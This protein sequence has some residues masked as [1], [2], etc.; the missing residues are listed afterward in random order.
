MELV[1]F[2]PMKLLKYSIS[3]IVLLAVTIACENSHRN[4]YSTKRAELMLIYNDYVAHKPLPPF[5]KIDS[6]LLYFEKYG[7]DEER[8]LSRYCKGASYYQ[9]NCRRAAYMEMRKSY[10]DAPSHLSPMNREI[11][12]GVL[13]HLQRLCIIDCNY[14]EAEQWWQKADSLKVHNEENMYSHY[15]NKA[16]LLG[17][18]QR[19]DSCCFYLK[20]SLDNM[21][22]YASW[23]ENKSACL[24]D[25][26]AYYAAAGKTEEFKEVYELL[27]LH[28]YHGKEANK[29]V[30]L[31]LFYAQLGQRDS[32]DFYFREAME[33]P[34]IY[35][36]TAALQL[37]VSARNR[38]MHDSVFYYFQKCVTLYDSIVAEQ[39]NSYTRDVEAIYHNYEKEQKIAEQR[40]KIL[41]TELWLLVALVIALLGIGI[42]FVYRH[43]LTKTRKE[44]ECEQKRRE[45]VE[46]RLQ[47][48]LD[49]MP[50][51]QKAIEDEDIKERFNAMLNELACMADAKKSSS[52][53]QLAQLVCLFTALHPHA[54]EKMKS[55]YARIKS[56]DFVICTLAKF[57]F[58]QS[59]IAKLLNRENA[60][61]YHFR[62]R[63]SKGLTG[64]AI[65]RM[66]DF[67]AMLDERF[68]G[69][70]NE[71]RL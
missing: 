50:R 53:E 60:E 25:I 11:M 16:M 27:Q 37:G 14:T 1:N 7:T 62:L 56:T 49:E 40:M 48:T 46:T 6:L 66:S 15:F 64:E 47:E 41:R 38:Q 59:Q 55:E 65:V 71:T 54:Y 18:D 51:R 43:H 9:D 22:Q 57:N 67:K 44:L 24:N 31:G 13:Y 34:P 30:D 63:I 69:E 4:D 52:P 12:R 26:S 29:K 19:E 39:G 42:A 2:A 17:Y 33:L 68:F 32:A 21:R 23:D 36:L 28:P 3:I 20:K 35:A 61:I 45:E 70:D 8:L 10:E 5:A 58:K